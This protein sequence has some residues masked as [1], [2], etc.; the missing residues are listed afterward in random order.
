[1][2]AEPRP[3]RHLSHHDRRRRFPHEVFRE[4]LAK[5]SPELEPDVYGAGELITSFER[6]VATLL[7]KEAALFLPSGTMA[8]QIALRVL[9]DRNKIPRVAFHATCHLERDE[10]KA[11]QA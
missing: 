8:Q 9:T 11:Y 3:R 5:T 10:Q 7:G 2:A 6:E 1:M 4:L